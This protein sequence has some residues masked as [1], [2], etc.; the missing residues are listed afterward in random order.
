MYTGDYH[1]ACKTDE[2]SRGNWI[3][4]VDTCAVIGYIARVRNELSYLVLNGAY[5]LRS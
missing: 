1:K 2:S 4:I 3:V 5:N